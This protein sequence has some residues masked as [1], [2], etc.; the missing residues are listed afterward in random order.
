M[1]VTLNLLDLTPYKLCLLF[2]FWHASAPTNKTV[3]NGLLQCDWVTAFRGVEWKYIYVNKHQ[4]P[5]KFQVTFLVE[6]FGLRCDLWRIYSWLIFGQF[7]WN[8]EIMSEIYGTPIVSPGFSIFFL[9]SRDILFTVK[10]LLKSATL[11]LKEW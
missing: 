5:K 8:V 6:C 11:K 10:T 4:H 1:C 9:L 2:A 7:S 3:S